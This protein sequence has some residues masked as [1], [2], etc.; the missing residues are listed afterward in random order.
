MKFSDKA[1]CWWYLKGGEDLTKI[2]VAVLVIL[3]LGLLVTLL[4]PES[5]RLSL[6]EAVRFQGSVGPLLL[7]RWSLPRRCS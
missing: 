3:A 6:A 2:V 1:K 4:V 5:L 7:L